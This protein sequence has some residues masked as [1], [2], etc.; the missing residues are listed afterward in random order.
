MELGGTVE[1]G[2]WQIPQSE[3]M[4][5]HFS[6]EPLCVFMITDKERVKGGGSQKVSVL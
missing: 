6:L 4:D 5:L 3:L 1:I 2:H